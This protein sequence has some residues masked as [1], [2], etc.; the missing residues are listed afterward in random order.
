METDN[1]A[2]LSGPP[3]VSREGLIEELSHYDPQMGLVN[4][5]L[6]VANHGAR[7]HSSRLCEL[8]AGVRPPAHHDGA[9]LRELSRLVTL[10]WR[11]ELRAARFE[12]ASG[13]A[14]QHAVHVSEHAARVERELEA[15]RHQAE[16]LGRHTSAV[17]AEAEAAR[18]ARDRAERERDRLAGELGR[19]GAVMDTRRVRGG[20]FVGRVADAVRRRVSGR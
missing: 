17:E 11:A 15:L 12:D 14:S 4:R 5:E 7:A 8:L 2:G 16:A 18:Q 19:A 10:Q 1:F 6:V 9:P 20:L 13:R 3:I